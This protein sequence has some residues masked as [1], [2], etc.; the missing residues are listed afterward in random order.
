MNLQEQIISDLTGAM[1]AKNAGKVSTLR[2]V[3][4]SL[5]NRAID[6]G[7]ALTNDEIIKMLQSLVKQ[8]RDSAEAYE[9]AKRSDLA[10]KESAEIGVIENYLPQAAL[11]VE[12]DQAVA[13]AIASTG[14]VSMKDMGTVMKAAMANLAGRPADGKLISDTVKTKLGG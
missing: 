8:R 2:M 9:K 1:K 13:E 3:K 12:I 10:D 11:S 4:A 14:A 5:M 7:A 6:K